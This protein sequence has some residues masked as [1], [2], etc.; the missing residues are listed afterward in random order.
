MFCLFLS[1]RLRQVLL[2]NA[3]SNHILFLVA[4]STPK[5][6]SSQA[7]QQSLTNGKYLLGMGADSV[8]KFQTRISVKNV[9]EEG[10][11]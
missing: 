9:K 7:P 10:A 6:T 1:G 8:L 2:F 3:G 11:D 5:P 4:A